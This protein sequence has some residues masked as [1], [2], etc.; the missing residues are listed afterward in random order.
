MVEAFDGLVS[1]RWQPEA[2]RTG[3]PEGCPTNTP[4]PL[5]RA[6]GRLGRREQ[7][8]IHDPADERHGHAG[9]AVL[10]Q[11]QQQSWKIR[12]GQVLVQFPGARPS[13]RFTVRASLAM[14]MTY[15]RYYAEAA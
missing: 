13:G 2:A 5:L 10:L 6:D 1:W 11:L 12:R 8:V 14:G 3:R 4:Q 15:A 9:D 7:I